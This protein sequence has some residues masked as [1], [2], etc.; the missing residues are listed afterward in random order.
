MMNLNS[1][2]NQVNIRF[3]KGK[4]SCHHCLS[5]R[6]T[7]HIRPLSSIKYFLEKMKF[8]ST[9]IFWASYSFGKMKNVRIL[10]TLSSRNLSFNLQQ[11][12]LKRIFWEGIWSWWLVLIARSRYMLSNP[13][14]FL[15][16]LETLVDSRKH[17]VYSLLLLLDTSQLRYSNLNS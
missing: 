14:C 9:K 3:T 1:S 13:I 2:K 16:S 5:M 4:T 12:K 15:G 8:A 17:W 10:M 6:L 11:L 7:R